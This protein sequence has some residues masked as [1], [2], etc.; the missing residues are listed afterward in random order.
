MADL[1]FAWLP[2]RPSAG[3]RRTGSPEQSYAARLWAVLNLFC[4]TG[5]QQDKTVYVVPDENGV[6]AD[7][8]MRRKVATASHLT[9]SRRCRGRPRL[10]QYRVDSNRMCRLEAES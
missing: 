6:C 3:W 7:A 1:P 5:R 8:F 2:A 10:L 4:R 9:K